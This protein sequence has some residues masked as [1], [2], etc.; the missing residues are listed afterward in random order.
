MELGISIMIKKPMKQKPGF[1]SFMSP[2][3]T[4]VWAAV[5]AIFLAVSL[6][7]FSV[8]RWSK[9]GWRAIRRSTSVKQYVNDFTLGNSLW[10]T[11]GSLLR[12]GNVTVPRYIPSS[13]QKVFVDFVGTNDPLTPAL[14]R[15][16]YFNKLNHERRHR[17]NN[18]I[19]FV[20]TSPLGLNWKFKLF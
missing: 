18:K 8:H 16:R 19:S 13:I 20:V 17:P 6:V 12:A 1:L 11:L 15:S 14:T 9:S 3:A 10:F 2:L 5:G 7:L 4:E